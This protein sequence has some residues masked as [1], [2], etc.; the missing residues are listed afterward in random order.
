MRIG[1]QGIEGS[2]S[3]AVAIEFA[4]TL[5]GNYSLIPLTNSNNVVLAL[6][7]NKIDYGIMATFNILGGI[8]KETEIAL[9]NK[10][11]EIVKIVKIPI[12]HCIFKKRNVDISKINIIASHEQA[13]KQTINNRKK[14]FPN[15]KAINVEDTALAAKYLSENVFEDNVAIICRKNAGELFNLDLIYENIE[16]DISNYTE[17]G[18]YRKKSIK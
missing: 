2:N 13:L 4:N 7:E 3:E 16:D 10:D 6:D 14:L 1:Y 9:K 18:I 8:V 17:F 15:S 11:F 12:H 5:G